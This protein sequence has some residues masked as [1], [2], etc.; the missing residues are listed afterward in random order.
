MSISNT[1]DYIDGRDIVAELEDLEA[2]LTAK[3]EELK[4]SFFK[5]DILYAISDLEIEYAPLKELHAAMK[6]APYSFV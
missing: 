1:D 3:K 5:D 6:T 4:E 2:E